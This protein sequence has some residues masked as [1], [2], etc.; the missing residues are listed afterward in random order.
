MSQRRPRKSFVKGAPHPKIRQYN[1]GTDKRFELEVHMVP[2]IRLQLRDNSIE[3]ARQAANKYLEK[4]LMDNFFFQVV[5]FP[6]LVVREHTALGVAGADRISKGMKAAFGKPKGRMARV[7]AGEP[8]FR[9]RVMKKDLPALKEALRRSMRKLSGNYSL[10]IRDITVDPKN[11]LRSVL[12]RKMKK[13]EEEKPVVEAA[14]TE[15]GAVPAEGAAAGKEVAAK[16]VE[17]KGSPMKTL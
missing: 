8:V 9:A 12:G 15:A 17:K 13:R 14:K 7:K 1:M 11:L 4:T 5:S 10:I 3:A 6:H 2:D 16:P